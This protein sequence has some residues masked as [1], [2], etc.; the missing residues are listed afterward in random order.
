M[1]ARTTGKGPHS[2]IY[3]FRPSSPLPRPESHPY[4]R[5][6]VGHRQAGVTFTAKIYD[7]MRS[8]Q[9]RGGCSSHLYTR[10]CDLK[11][12]ACEDNSCEGAL[13]SEPQSQAGAHAGA[14]ECLR[15][16]IKAQR[17]SEDQDLHPWFAEDSR[18]HSVE[19]PASVYPSY[20]AREEGE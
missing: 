20:G 5:S 9:L 10:Q 7:G 11:E 1:G 13:A 16:K 8:K 17:S 19:N 18:P 12:H 2:S 4:I 3:A 14:G 6:K 15:K